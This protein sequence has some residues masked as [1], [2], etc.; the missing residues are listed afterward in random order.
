MPLEIRTGEPTFVNPVSQVCTESQIRSIAYKFWSDEIKEPSPVFHRKQW[1]WCY[2]LQALAETGCLAPDRRGIAF[3]VGREPVVAACAK[4]GCRVLATD[5]S[6]EQAK[7]QGWVSTNEYAGT[8]TELNAR[9]ICDP[10]LF[11]D[12]VSFQVSDMNQLDPSWADFDFTWSSCSLEHLGSLEKGLAF[13]RNSLVC[14]RPGGVAVHTTEYNISS[15]DETVDE[16]D[17]VLYRKKDILELARGLSE[18]GHTVILNLDLGEG[19][20]DKHVDVPPF[21]SEPV[22]F[23]ATGAVGGSARPHLKLKVEGFTTT[24]LGLIIEKAGPP[25]LLRV[26]PQ[27]RRRSSGGPAFIYG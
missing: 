22:P 9:A 7:A 2:I 3:G 8:L 13:I 21:S 11:Q 1:E 12:S 20:L 15:D 27:H 24:S 16:G 14:L 10:K 23:T 5:Q 18:C 25:L 6:Y 26:T 4:H 19:A 17:Y